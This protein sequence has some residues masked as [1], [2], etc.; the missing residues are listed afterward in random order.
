MDACAKVLR[1]AQPVEITYPKR[2]KSRVKQDDYDTFTGSLEYMVERL[3]HVMDTDQERVADLLEDLEDALEIRERYE[4]ERPPS[5]TKGVTGPGDRRGAS[6]CPRAKMNE[7]D[8]PRRAR[9]QE[10]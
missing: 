6:G 3:P 10:Q 8:E 4:Q 7:P 9:Q 2:G 1:T 5:H